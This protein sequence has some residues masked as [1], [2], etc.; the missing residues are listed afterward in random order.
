M[1]T[2]EAGIIWEDEVLADEQGFYGLETEQVRVNKKIRIAPIC[3]DD[4]L[5]T[6]TAKNEAEIREQAYYFCLTKNEAKAAFDEEIVESISW[7]TRKNGGRQ[8]LG[9][10]AGGLGADC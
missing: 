6:P 7:K 5:H 3:Y 4:I 9:R 1:F 10:P 2:N 8:D